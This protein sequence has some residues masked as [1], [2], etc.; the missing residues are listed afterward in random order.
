M[1]KTA[2]EIIKVNA[3]KVDIIITP[4][5]CTDFVVVKSL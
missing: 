2:N 5:K 4:E 3:S 1:R